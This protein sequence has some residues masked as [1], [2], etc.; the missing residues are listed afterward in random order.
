VSERSSEIGGAY[1]TVKL[2]VANLLA[3]ALLAFWAWQLTFPPNLPTWVEVALVPLAI[4]GW[5]AIYVAWLGRPTREHPG[6]ANDTH[7]NDHKGT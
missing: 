1:Q 2:I 6:E 5:G 4:V 3:I 7:S